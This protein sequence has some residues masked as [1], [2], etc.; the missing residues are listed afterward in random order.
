MNI[1]KKIAPICLAAAMV[2]TGTLPAWAASD[3]T[4]TEEEW[5]KLRDNTLEYGEL[6][7]LIHEYNVTVL[8]NR[9]DYFKVKN[10]TQQE[11]SDSYRSQAQELY[12]SIQYPDGSDEM[13]YAIAYANA[14]Q[15]ENA[16][17]SMEQ[18]ADENVDD[19]QIRKIQ[20]DQVEDTLVTSAQTLMNSYHQLLQSKKTLEANMAL[21]K[22][23]YDVTVRQHGLNMVTQ[24]DVYKAEEQVKTAEAGLISLE[25]NI[26]KTKQS[27][28]MMTGW[29]YDANPEIISIP[30]A[31]VKRI[32]SMNPETD[33]EAAKKNNY[34][35]RS[36]RRKL[37][38]SSSSS[39]KESLENAIKDGEQKIGAALN[40]QSQTVLQAKADYD[41]SVSEYELEL[42]SMGTAQRKYEQG[43][44]S[45]IEYMKA[46]AAYIEKETKR[47]IKDLALE[48]AMT[49]YDWA[50]KGLLSL[51]Q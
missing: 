17:K 10:R 1:I 48:Q 4:R 41:Q 16:A 15:L 40:N 36:D 2:G 45:A 51:G 27:L 18:K 44:T 5:T 20:Y 23:S 8:N 30:P 32:A 33:L 46:Q 11:I 6:G 13:T 7:A 34:A 47:A 49:T 25:A 39:S 26:K 24:A 9:S 19:G 43:M 50:V 31:D 38:N 42:K 14:L 28:C 22:A 21:V 35:L 12:G 3:V 29:S 37:E